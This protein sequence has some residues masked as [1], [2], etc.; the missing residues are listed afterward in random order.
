MYMFQTITLPVLF[1]MYIRYVTS[2]NVGC[3]DGL[4]NTGTPKQK[5]TCV[6]QLYNDVG[7]CTDVAINNITWIGNSSVSCEKEELTDPDF[8]LRCFNT[9]FETEGAK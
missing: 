2:T 5:A 3:T 7:G 9:R 1:L 4:N 8:V 6:C